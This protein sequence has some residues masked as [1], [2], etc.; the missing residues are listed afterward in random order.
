MLSDGEMSYLY[1][2]FGRLEQVTKADGSFQKNHYNAEGLRAEM[3]EN[4][5]LVKFLY[6]ED[7]EAAAEEESDGNVIRYIRGLGLISSDSEKA[8]TYYHY[9]SDEQG[10]ITHVINGEE[11]ESGELPQEDVQSRVLNHYEYDAF[12]NT[13][14]CEEQVENRFRYQGE[15]YDPITQQYYLRARY[16]NPVIG[17]FIQEDTY[18]GDGLNLYTY[19]RNN[20]ILNHDPTGH[21]TKENSPYSRKE[22]QYIDAGADPDT[23]RLAAECYP[24]AKSKQD[25]YNKYKK[26]GYSAQDAKK[27]ANREIIH[28][29]EATKKYIKDNNVKKSGPDYTATSPRDNVN[30]D[31]RTQERLNAQ[32]NNRKTI[33]SV[34]DLTE[35][36]KDAIVRYTGDDYKNINNSLRGLETAT[37]KNQTTIDIMK[38]ALKNA[39][40]PQNMTLYRGTSTEA[41]GNLKN[42]S[43]EQLVGKQFVEAGFMSTS[44]NKQVANGT[45]SGNMQIT[46]KAQKGAKALN[47]SSISQYEGEAEILFNAGQKMVITD[48]KNVNGILHITVIVK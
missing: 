7:R 3:E 37:A 22:Q 6:N 2:G 21:G 8:K 35:T 27:L 19:C 16:Y 17:R 9:V 25:L 23:A 30:T 36:Q 24:D 41:L 33:S 1:D 43:P 34:N 48:A 47:I 29:E 42:L 4:G 31:W 5:Q 20:P 13:I 18:Y 12:G 45:F 38:S 32:N 39:S 15:Q 10:S 28:G 26:Q 11:K 44:A 14:R 40:L 46:I